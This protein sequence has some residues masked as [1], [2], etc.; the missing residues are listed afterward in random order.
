MAFGHPRKHIRV[1]IMLPHGNRRNVQPETAFNMSDD[2]DR[3]LDIGAEAGVSG[4][5][6]FRG[7]Q[8]R[9]TSLRTCLRV[10]RHGA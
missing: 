7:G 3:D 9:A 8:P 6:S 10:V 5:A 2:P 1:N 4:E